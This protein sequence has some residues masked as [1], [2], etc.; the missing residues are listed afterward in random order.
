[1]WNLSG[2]V[3]GQVIKPKCIICDKEGNAYVSDEAT[4]KILK[5]NSLTGEVSGILLLGEVKEKIRSICWSNTEPN[6]TVL[7]GNRI[8]TYFLPK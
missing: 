6:L 4:N 7:Q 3:T 1:M 2:P 5:I 8:N